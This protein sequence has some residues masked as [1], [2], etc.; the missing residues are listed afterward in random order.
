MSND[1]NEESEFA[2]G[3]A[4]AYERSLFDFHFDENGNET[5]LSPAETKL[6]GAARKGQLCRVESHGE[7][8]NFKNV[9]AGFLRFLLLGGDGDAPVHERGV[10]LDGAIVTGTLNLDGTTNVRPLLLKDC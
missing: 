1:G 10:Q 8:D 5:G 2:G 6:L 9:R 4:K 3:R 7:G